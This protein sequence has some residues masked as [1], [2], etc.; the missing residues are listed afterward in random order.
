[1]TRLRQMMLVELERRNF[2][3]TLLK[4]LSFLKCSRNQGVEVCPDIIP[5][6]LNL[7]RWFE[8]AKDSIR[9]LAGN[10]TVNVRNNFFNGQPLATFGT[11]HRHEKLL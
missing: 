3:E 4:K 2:A 5:L 1:M 11:S 9:Q 7:D 6:P 10:A 8:F